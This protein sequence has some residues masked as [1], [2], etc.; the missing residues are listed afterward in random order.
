MFNQVIQ[1]MDRPRAQGE[2]SLIHKSN[3]G[4]SRVGCWSNIANN[5]MSDFFAVVAIFRKKPLCGCDIP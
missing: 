3:K 1:I 2:N 5:R 4:C